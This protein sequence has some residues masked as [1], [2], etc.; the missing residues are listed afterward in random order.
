[1]IDIATESGVLTKPMAAGDVVD[2]ETLMRAVALAN[3]PVGQ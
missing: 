2:R 1:M 3:Q